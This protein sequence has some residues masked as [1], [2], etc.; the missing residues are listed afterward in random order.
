[1]PEKVVEQEAETEEF[2]RELQRS[3]QAA[4]NVKVSPM[5]VSIIRGIYRDLTSPF[6]Q[7]PGPT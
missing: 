1:M 4:V 3:A 5:F 2:E 7:G 6:R